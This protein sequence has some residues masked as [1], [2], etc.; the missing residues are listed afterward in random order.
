MDRAPATC[1]LLLPR[2]R[3]PQVL[4]ANRDRSVAWWRG[5]SVARRAAIP[6]ARQHGHWAAKPVA[7]AMRRRYALVSSGKTKR[8]SGNQCLINQLLRSLYKHG[9][10]P[11]IQ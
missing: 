8:L 9:K 6:S 5:D 2:T 4:A 1:G 3:A 10:K 11:L 7:C